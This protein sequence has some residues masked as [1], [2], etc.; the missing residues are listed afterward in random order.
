MAEEQALLSANFAAFIDV[1]EAPDVRANY[2]IGITT[3]DAG[4]PR[5][6]NTTPENGQP[7]A[8]E[9]RRPGGGGEFTFNDDDFS[10]ACTTSATR[11]TRT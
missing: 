2:R 5:C 4:N 3:T 1:L 7:G 11:P 9:L 6:P 10:F 8:V